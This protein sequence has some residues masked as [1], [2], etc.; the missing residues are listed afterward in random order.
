M[1]PLRRRLLTGAFA[2]L[3]LAI[4]GT[5]IAG[6]TGL[7]G[8]PEDVAPPA[9]S[10]SAV[11]GGVLVADPGFWDGVAPLSFD[12]R[13]ERC[14]AVGLGCVEGAGATG[15]SYVLSSADVGSRLVVV[16][17]ASNSVGSA[18]VVS[19]A[20]DVVGA[21]APSVVRWPHVSGVV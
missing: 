14:D 18:S 13:W 17:T 12:Y 5:P 21:V 9:I 16:V 15:A 2:A 11:D 1:L 7:D 3:V 8:A 19:A 4:A 6:A 10:G 20:T